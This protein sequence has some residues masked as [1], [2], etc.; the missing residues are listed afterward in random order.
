MK[1]FSPVH[2]QNNFHHFVCSKYLTIVGGDFNCVD[3]PTLD[4]TSYDA[5]KLYSSKSQNSFSLCQTFDLHDVFENYKCPPLP[6]LHS[7]ALQLHLD[8]IDFLFPLL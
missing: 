6:I 3:N 8:Y 7:M 2:C 4:C 5:H 1:T